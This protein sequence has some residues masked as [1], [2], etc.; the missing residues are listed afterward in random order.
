MLTIKEHTYSA[1]P[2]GLLESTLN[3]RY[4]WSS[5][6]RMT[7]RFWSVFGRRDRLTSAEHGDIPPKSS[8]PSPV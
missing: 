7:S 3:C 1:P 2:T 4:R 8:P 6:K 5:E